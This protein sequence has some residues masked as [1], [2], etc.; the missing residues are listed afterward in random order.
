M[1]LEAVV[2]CDF[3]TLNGSDIKKYDNNVVTTK[4]RSSVFLK[5]KKKE[6][7]TV[8]RAPGLPLGKS[9]AGPIHNMLRPRPVL[10]VDIIRPIGKTALQK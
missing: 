8:A 2:N 4:K 1:S 7:P 10:Y 6:A 5:K 9:G 3:D